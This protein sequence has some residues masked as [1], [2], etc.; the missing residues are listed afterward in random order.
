MDAP[1]LQVYHPLTE[2]TVRTNQYMAMQIMANL[3]FDGTSRLLI[4][5]VRYLSCRRNSD[6]A[7]H[8]YICRFV[9]SRTLECFD[10]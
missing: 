6:S 10:V 3:F 1:T 8:R 5:P 2:G 4:L 9:V 7:F